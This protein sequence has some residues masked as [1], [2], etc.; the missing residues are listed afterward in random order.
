MQKV[1]KTFY[2]INKILMIWSVLNITNKITT[3]TNKMSSVVRF[4]KK[5]CKGS[6]TIWH[7]YI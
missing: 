7:Y 2:K 6:K 1:N 4:P 5:Y 3:S